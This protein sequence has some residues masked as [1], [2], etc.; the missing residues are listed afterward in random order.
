M[1]SKLDKVVTLPTDERVLTAPRC[2]CKA[3]AGGRPWISS[4][5]GIA[6][7]LNNLRA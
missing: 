7:W 5:S 2:C 1:R 4:T 3:T 6:I